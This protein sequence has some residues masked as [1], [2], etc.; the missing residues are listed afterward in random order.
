MSNRSD[1]DFDDDF[2]GD[3]GRNS[4]SSF[5]FGDEAELPPIDFGA[6]EELPPMDDQPEPGGTSRA[7]VILAI[8][9]MLTFIGGLVLAVILITQPQG[10]SPEAITATYVSEFN[11]TQIAFLQ[12]TQTQARG[13]EL[14]TLTAIAFTDTPS[15]TLTPS[16]TPTNTPEPSPTL[17]PTLDPALLT[18]TE[19]ISAFAA[20]STAVARLSQTPEAGAPTEEVKPE[21]PSGQIVATRTPTP[22]SLIQTP[23]AATLTP[24][25]DGGAIGALNQTATQIVSQ[26]LTATAQAGGPG[27]IV[28][29]T[30]TV[31]GVGGGGVTTPTP[32]GF[33]GLIPTPE[34][35]PDTGLFDG[36]VGGG[37]AA[38]PA[39]AMMIVGLV[40]VIFAARKLRT[41]GRKPSSRR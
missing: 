30:P 36:V 32:G 12:A 26:F 2:F 27:V 40:G 33:V 4:G 14:A 22:V 16:E 25:P 41:G 17:Q 5:D 23:V 10:P 19:V 13:N 3:S 35:L 11:A 1:F 15:P 28:E 6:G 20:T 24:T 21:T 34:M 39:L 7:F 9:M 18:A 37:A 31:E 29:A 8:L 38:I